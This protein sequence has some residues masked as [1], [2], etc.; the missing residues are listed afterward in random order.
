MDLVQNHEICAPEWKPSLYTRGFCSESQVA[1][2]GHPFIVIDLRRTWRDFPFDDA[3][4][5]RKLQ[6]TQTKVEFLQARNPMARFAD[7]F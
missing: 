3:F 6:G 4:L 5:D 1:Q 7:H 2:C